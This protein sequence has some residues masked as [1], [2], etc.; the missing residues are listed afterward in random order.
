MTDP[1]GVTMEFKSRQALAS[2]LADRM[3]QNGF[4]DE[5]SLKVAQGLLPLFDVSQTQTK[6]FGR[7]FVK[8]WT[9]RDDDL[10]LIDLICS[11]LTV[12]ALAATGG[13]VLAVSAATLAALVKVIYV[14]VKKGV[15]ITPAQHKILLGLKAGSKGRTIEE[16]VAW[17]R[18]SY[19]EEDWSLTT[20]EAELTTLQSTA[21]NDGTV[22]KLADKSSG[23]RW[24]AAGV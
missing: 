6:G 12:G 18:E 1:E 10:K 8:R 3:S 16:L 23:N 5:M 4:P 9:I 14:L 24:Y 2:F 19:C 22:V 7:I 21:L 13:A 20:V 11:G 15:K 17:L